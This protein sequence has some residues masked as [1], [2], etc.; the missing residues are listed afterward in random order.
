MCFSLPDEDYVILF[1]SSCFTFS[2][3]S[4]PVHEG[5][6][7]L[8]NLGPVDSPATFFLP[9]LQAKMEFML[10]IADGVSNSHGQMGLMSYIVHG[11]RPAL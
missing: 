6:V 4:N 3:Y 2:S 8:S 5:G 9:I 7:F 11:L 10:S 1:V